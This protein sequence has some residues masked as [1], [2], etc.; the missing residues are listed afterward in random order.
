MSVHTTT[1]VLGRLVPSLGDGTYEPEGLDCVVNPEVALESPLEYELE[2]ALTKYI[3]KGALITR[4]FKVPTYRGT[5]RVDLVIQTKQGLI[6]FECDGRDYHD[7][8][9]DI[10]RDAIILNYSK[11]ESI[12]RIAGPD[13][14]YRIATALYVIGRR[15]PSVFSEHGMKNLWAL[16][17]SREFAYTDHDD[18]GIYARYTFIDED[19]KQ[20]DRKIYIRSLSRKHRDY[21]LM[22]AIAKTYRSAKTEELWSIAMRELMGRTHSQTT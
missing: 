20:Y 19:E 11:I 21:S 18:E 14:Y 1:E 12:Y 15:V 10:F 2:W 5:F 4:Q 13:I 7:W 6:G 17:E 16:S 9:R 22:L 8:T 3:P